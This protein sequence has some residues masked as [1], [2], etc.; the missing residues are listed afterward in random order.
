MA[1][2]FS[3]RENSRLL[4]L[5]TAVVVVATLYVARGVL[6]PLALGILFAFL[7]SPPVTLLGRLR[8][9]RVLATLLVVLSTIAVVG[10]F[11][12]TVARQVIDVTN[13][14]PNYRTNIT[15]KIDAFHKSSD[16][17]FGRATNTVE[18][19]QKEL[20]GKQ[21]GQQPAKGTKAKPLTPATPNPV[22]VQV[23][24]STA[25]SLITFPKVVSGLASVGL[26]VIFTFF[27][28]LQ[29]E[30]LR[31]R[32]IRLAGAGRLTVMTQALD[33]AAHR[34]SRYLLLQ[35][36]VNVSYGSVVGVSLHFIGIP[37]AL[38][39]GAIAGVLRFL[40]YVGPPM[41]AL[42]PIVLSL[43]IYDGWSKPL[44][45]IG[46]FV[47]LELMVAYFIEPMLYGAQTGV[48]PIAIL[49]AAVFW[50]TVWGPIGLLLSTP[51][52]VCLVVI[53][54][55][56]THLNFLQILLGDTPAL[57]P[58]ERF[59]QR[60]LATDQDE[61]RQILEDDFKDK[62]LDELYDTVL[63]P[64]LALAEQDRHRANL[65]EATERFIFQSTRELVEEQFERSKSS[66]LRDSLKTAVDAPATLPVSES[67]RTIPFK[68]VTVPA[69]DEADEI[70]AMMLTQ[71]LQTNG[72]DAQCLPV[73][74][75]SEYLAQIARRQPDLVCISA[76]PPLAIAYARTLYR[77][78]REQ[79]PGVKV[80][81]G[82]WQLA[83]D[84]EKVATRIGADASVMS[85]TLQDAV[86][87]INRATQPEPDI[88]VQADE[89]V[90][91]KA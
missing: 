15:A 70:I 16:S 52:T 39:W 72:Y 74:D 23:V 76:L 35:L 84:A 89:P 27:M 40:P 5:A 90:K 46:T 64:A 88:E 69:R 30:D 17:A 68:I 28:L 33:E 66:N 57:A 86:H 6:V 61:A 13:E 62:P 32:L 20:T 3:S 65:D 63:I 10:T 50:T 77:K 18:E 9:G 82:L 25:D 11:G 29:R 38:L 24:G 41:G 47:M 8:L 75:S 12:W 31:N 87:Q 4:A 54:H 53:G 14:L 19:L 42:C 51:L 80:V 36:L 91:A 43:I 44:M 85:A 7:L 26:V 81:I 71:L 73:S 79:F 55:H 58:E 56:I 59:Y 60:L 21:N 37:N 22:Q 1:R 45:T 83:G 49:F 34:V 48:T 78:V 2:Q 67:K